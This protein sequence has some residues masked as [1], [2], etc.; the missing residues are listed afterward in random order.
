[1]AEQPD[2]VDPFSQMAAGAAAMHEMFTSFLAAG[3]ARYEALWLT[4]ALAQGLKP[5]PGWDEPEKPDG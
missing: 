5:P 2:P 3:F 1:M 4:A